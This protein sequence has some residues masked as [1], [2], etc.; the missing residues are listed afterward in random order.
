MLHRGGRRHEPE[1][2]RTD[3]DH[4][5][6]RFQLSG[7]HRGDHNAPLR[8]ILPK[9]RHQNFAQNDHTQDPE[10]QAHEA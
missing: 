4:L 7:A 3:P 6:G 10:R 9:E 8:G 2:C 5:E 1:E